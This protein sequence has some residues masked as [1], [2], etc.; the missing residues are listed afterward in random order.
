MDSESSSSSSRQADAQNQ[1]QG[2]GVMLAIRTAGIGFESV[3][4][5]VEERET[6]TGEGKEGKE[7]E[8]VYWTCVAE[9][10]LALFVA[11]V[12]ARFGFNGERRERLRG[13]IG[14]MAVEMDGGVNGGSEWEDRDV[15]R[16]RKRE[17]GLRVKEMRNGGGEKEESNGHGDGDEDGDILGDTTTFFLNGP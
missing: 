17:E 11:V 14:S 16:R 15:R 3:I 5:W 10:V 13:E 8:E 7:K 6:E 9:E 12:N 2:S 1:G 4:G